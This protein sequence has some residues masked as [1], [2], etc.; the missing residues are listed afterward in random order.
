M[1]WIQ[2]S[3]KAI[4]RTLN[5]ARDQFPITPIIGN[6]SLESMSRYS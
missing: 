4:R 3:F 5:E 2:R 1:T 6:S